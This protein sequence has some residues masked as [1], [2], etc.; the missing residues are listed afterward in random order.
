MLM[1][2]ICKYMLSKESRKHR[3]WNGFAGKESKNLRNFAMNGQKFRNFAKL[4][5]DQG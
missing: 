4:W 5:E 2:N 1:R 3:L